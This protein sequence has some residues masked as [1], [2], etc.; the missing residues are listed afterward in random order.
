[1][2]HRLTRR[3]LLPP[4]PLI[5]LDDQWNQDKPLPFHNR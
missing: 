5:Q 2:L 3:T 1:M 4:L